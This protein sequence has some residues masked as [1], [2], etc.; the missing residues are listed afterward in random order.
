MTRVSRSRKSRKLEKKGE[1]RLT[2]EIGTVIEHGDIFFLYRP[3]IDTEEVKDIESVQRFYMVISPD[4]SDIQRIFFMGQKQL[5]EIVEG[6]STSE[7]RNWALNVLTSSNPNEIR[8]E[9]LPAEYQTETRGR[10]S[11]CGARRRRKIFDCTGYPMFF[12]P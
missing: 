2:K 7:E 3:K 12:L 1:Q 9:F 5:P 8:K 4:N 6:K 11:C 10:V